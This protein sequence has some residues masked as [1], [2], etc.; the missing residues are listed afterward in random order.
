MPVCIKCGGQIA[1]GGKFCPNCGA[2]VVVPKPPK[3]REARE[4]GEGRFGAPDLLSLIGAL[5]L[6]VGPFLTWGE[7]GV[8]IQGLDVWTWGTPLYVLGA[9]CLV[10]VI[11]ARN[12]GHGVSGLVY[13]ALAFCALAIVGHFIYCMYDVDGDWH[14]VGEGFYVAGAGAALVLLGGIARLLTKTA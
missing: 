2:K 8:S 13:V 9:L 7:N 11:V 10:A 5:A 6:L 4:I 14:T 12:L 1:E 3:A